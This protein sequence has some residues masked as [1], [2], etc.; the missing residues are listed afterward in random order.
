LQSKLQN[1]VKDKPVIKTVIGVGFY[2]G[3]TL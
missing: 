3:Q 1:S 2:I